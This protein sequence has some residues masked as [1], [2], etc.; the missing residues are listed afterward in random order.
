MT[1][2]FCQTNQS[3]HFHLACLVP[4]SHNSHHQFILFTLAL[5]S[6][7]NGF[8]TTTLH[9]LRNGLRCRRQSSHDNNKLISLR[10]PAIFLRVNQRRLTSTTSPKSWFENVPICHLIAC[11]SAVFLLVLAS[12]QRASNL[13]L[14]HF[15]ELQQEYIAGR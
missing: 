12:A 11:S 13:H 5:I 15:V 1:S 8:Y 10:L 4:C 2:H 9:Q 6:G 3:A 14:S 7:T